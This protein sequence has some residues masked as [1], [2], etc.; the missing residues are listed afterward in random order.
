[1][2]LDLR[3]APLIRTMVR[4]KHDAKPLLGAREEL[5]IRTKL[6]RCSTKTNG[7]TLLRLDMLLVDEWLQ[8]WALGEAVCW[9]VL[10][11]SIFV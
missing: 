1:M 4:W 10:N 7:Q 8:G 2:A 11:G 6:S 3:Q 9:L 5:K